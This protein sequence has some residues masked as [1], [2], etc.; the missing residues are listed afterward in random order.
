MASS[1]SNE[2]LTIDS[3]SA[4]TDWVISMPTRRY[5]VAGRGRTVDGVSSATTGIYSPTGKGGPTGAFSNS[6]GGDSASNVTQYASNGRSS[7]V[8]TSAYAYFDREENTPAAP[9]TGDVIS[10]STPEVADVV[11]L[12][13][14]V[15]VVG[16]NQTGLTASAVMGGAVAYT[17]LD[18][19]AG[20]DE[21]WAVLGLSFATSDNTVRNTMGGL[22][23][24][25]QAFVTAFNPATPDGA[26]TYGANW[27]HRFAPVP[28][29]TP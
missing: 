8:R 2:Y 21:G 26:A 29:V 27:N 5:H 24:I 20:Y 12:C 15:T 25:G 18:L 4:A 6:L 16:V 23:V 10:P 17:S 28:S 11:Q 7:C 14:E 19:D 13:G 1:I 22:P 3:V 9:A